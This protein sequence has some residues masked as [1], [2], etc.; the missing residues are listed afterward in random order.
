MPLQVDA[1]DEPA[2]NLTPLVDVLFLLLIFFLVGTR[3]TQ[4]ENSFEIELPTASAAPE[5]MTGRPDELVVNVGPE[6]QL[7][8]LGQPLSIERLRERLAEF[9]EIYPDQVV[10]VRGDASGAYQHVVSVMDAV[11]QAGLT[12]LSL[13]V[14]PVRGDA[15]AP[16]PV[17]PEAGPTP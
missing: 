12:N 5:P 17:Q 14:E 16:I 13:A 6:G 10:V 2:L 1:A 9:A 3:F 4:N 8:L 7:T 15:A 11:N